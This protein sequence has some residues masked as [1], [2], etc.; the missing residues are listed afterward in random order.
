MTGKC[1]K[2]EKYGTPQ[3]FLHAYMLQVAYSKTSN[4]RPTTFIRTLAC[5]FMLIILLF[6]LI[7]GVWVR[8]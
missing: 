8:V 2:K 4:K 7:I 3:I 1:E 6:V 5:G